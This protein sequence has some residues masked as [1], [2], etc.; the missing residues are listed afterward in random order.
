[1]STKNKHEFICKQCG[2]YVHAG[3]GLVDLIDGR[4]QGVHAISCPQP[5]RHTYAG[6]SPDNYVDSLEWNGRYWEGAGAWMMN[7]GGTSEDVNPNE[8]SK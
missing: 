1:M 6:P 3:M 4:W 8:G 2:M 5:P 7:D